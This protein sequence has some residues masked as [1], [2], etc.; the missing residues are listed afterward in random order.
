MVVTLIT[1]F[2]AL[3]AFVAFTNG[4]FLAGLVMTVVTIGFAWA[5]RK[6]PGLSADIRAKAAHNVATE[7]AR[8]QAP[9]QPLPPAPPVNGWADDLSDLLGE[10][11]QAPPHRGGT[12]AW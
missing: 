8:R 7:L 5:A 3:V 11:R 10:S 4:G 6:L 12:E 9:P 2:F 1:V